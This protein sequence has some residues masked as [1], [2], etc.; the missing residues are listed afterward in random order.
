MFLNW[1]HPSK[2]RNPTGWSLGLPALCQC[3]VGH[4]IQLYYSYLLSLLIE[5]ELELMQYVSTDQTSVV[6]W[7]TGMSQKVMACL[8]CFM[9]VW[10]C[11]PV[12]NQGQERQKAPNCCSS[13][14]QWWARTLQGLL[15]QRKVLEWSRPSFR[16]G[17]QGARGSRCTIKSLSSIYSSALSKGGFIVSL[18]SD[19]GSVR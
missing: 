19:H 11:V 12:V 17:T 8:I 7:D 1:L 18:Q 14:C 16:A 4:L 2:K 15:H 6:Y 9:C 13:S 10:V 5:S 3:E